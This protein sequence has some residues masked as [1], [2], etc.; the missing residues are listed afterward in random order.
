V[1]GSTLSF[2]KES[3]AFAMALQAEHNALGELIVMI[4][5]APKA[6]PAEDL[7]TMPQ[8]QAAKKAHEAVRF[9]RTRTE[10]ARGQ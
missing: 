2:K 10:A 1:K 3:A 7:E 5:N 4:E 9:Q 8:M 6:C